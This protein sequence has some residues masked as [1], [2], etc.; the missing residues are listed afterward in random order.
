MSPTAATRAASNR[1]AAAKKVEEPAVEKETEQQLKNRLRNEAERE[2][3]NNHKDEFHTIAEAKFTAH[4]LVFVRRKT[5][6]EKAAEKIADLM[7]QFPELREQFTPS[8]PVEADVVAQYVP[9]TD[10]V[11]EADPAAYDSEDTAPEP[12]FHRVPEEYD[13]PEQVHGW[14]SDEL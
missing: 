11:D 9:V 8:T 5:E 12:E 7:N 2:V 3:L 6:Q 14:P 4:N 10:Q 1:S 13:V